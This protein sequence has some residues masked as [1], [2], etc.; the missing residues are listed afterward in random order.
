MRGS[1][2]ARRYVSAKGAARLRERL[3]ERDLCVIRQVA[4]L[5]LMSA[6]QIQALHFPDD[7]HEN[8]AAATRARQRVLRRLCRDGLLI[9]LERR[10]G[11]VRAGS[12]G[13]GSAL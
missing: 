5:R 10:I 8:G 7:E 1:T 12:A 9:P 6:V 13:L 11:G 4:E 3:S 2:S